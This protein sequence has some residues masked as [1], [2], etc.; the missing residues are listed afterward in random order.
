MWEIN[1]KDKNVH[2]INT[3]TCKLM[4]NMIVIVEL[5]YGIQ[6]RMERKRE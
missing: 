1:P 6:G 4:Q 2:K 5:L 3:I